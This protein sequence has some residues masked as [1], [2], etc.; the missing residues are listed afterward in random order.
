[1]VAVI[2]QC[3]EEEERRGD[4]FLFC[5]YMDWMGVKNMQPNKDKTNSSI[6]H[7]FFLLFLKKK[8]KSNIISFFLLL[9]NLTRL[10]SF[11]L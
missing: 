10:T 11:R 1:M 4:L 2:R 3:I 8:D 9:L 6:D 5:S 7:V